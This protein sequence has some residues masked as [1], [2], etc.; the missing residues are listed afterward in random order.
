MSSIILL[1]LRVIAPLLKFHKFYLMVLEL[2]EFLQ[3]LEFRIKKP[4]F[5]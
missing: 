5:D 1:N 2:L 3:F 4:A